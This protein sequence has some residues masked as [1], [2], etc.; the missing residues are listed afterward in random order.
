MKVFHY[1]YIREKKREA[2]PFC[3]CACTYLSILQ[4][5]FVSEYQ[6]LIYGNR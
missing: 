1:V 4:S 5:S 2:I 6:G 3:L